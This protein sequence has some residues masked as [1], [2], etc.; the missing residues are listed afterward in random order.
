MRAAATAFAAA[1]DRVSTVLA[2]LGI[3]ALAG[4][5]AVVV[6]DVAWRRIGGG[7]FIGSVDLTQLCVVAAVSWS[8][9]YA[10]CRGTH[11]AVDLLGTVLS[12]RAERI[13]DA[14]AAAVAMVLVGF[15][16]MLSW[17]RAMEQWGYGD[18][19]QDLAIPFVIHWSFLL[20]GLAV[21]AVACL[22]TLLVRATGARTEG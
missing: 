11:V 21:S 22:S 2:V 19:S 17:R 9:P 10:F 5:V 20:S 13:L 6:G 12:R 7:S 4:A 15:L 1:V 18:V 16:L 3:A 14:I 8:I